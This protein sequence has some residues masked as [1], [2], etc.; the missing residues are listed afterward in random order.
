[1][2]RDALPHI[3]GWVDRQQFDGAIARPIHG[4]ILTVLA[5]DTAWGEAALEVA[6]NSSEALLIAGLDAAG[7]DELLEQLTLIWDRMAAR[8]HVPW[9]ADIL[10]LL[11][12]FPGPREPLV[13]FAA[14][15][16]GPV[17]GA[18]ARVSRVH[19]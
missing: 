2:V 17:Q 19:P 14:G 6:Y 18:I 8:R 1:M 15:A 5:L 7:Y 4:A 3:I 16:V 9:L 11:E 10:E 13:R 12:L